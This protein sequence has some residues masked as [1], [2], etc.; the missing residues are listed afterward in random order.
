MKNPSFLIKTASRE[1]LQLLAM[2][3]SGE[4]RLFNGSLH[5]QL[6]MSSL[7]ETGALQTNGVYSSSKSNSF[8]RS[9]SSSS[10]C[11]NTSSTTCLRKIPFEPNP[12]PPTATGGGGLSSDESLQDD[13][14]SV[15]D[16][17]GEMLTVDQKRMRRMQANKRERKRMHTVNSA[18]DDLRELVPTY[19]SNRKLSKIETLRLACAYIEDLAKLLR[20]STG[21]AVVHGEDVNLHHHHHGNMH[22]PR[23]GGEGFT[24]STY[25]PI[26]NEYSR[27]Q[28]QDYNT[29][30]FQ[31]YRV[32]LSYVSY[33]LSINIFYHYFS[34]YLGL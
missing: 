32:P 21:P 11:S 29:C 33:C 34:S 19:P 6:N 28:Q 27:L 10:T 31:H 18:F 13:A 15:E 8:S 14:N 23:P 24:A 17:E 20:E 7:H 9:S 5:Y 25:S 4:Q 16:V 1:T 12:S 26:K 22:H 2:M 30:N 3:S